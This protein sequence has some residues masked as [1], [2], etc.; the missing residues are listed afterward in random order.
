VTV[1]T[2]S[3]IQST[4]APCPEFSPW[5]QSVGMDL[6]F[7]DQKANVETAFQVKFVFTTQSI[8]SVGGNISIFL[9]A[10][11]FS[12]KFS[13]TATLSP[14]SGNAALGGCT[15]SDRSALSSTWLQIDCVVISAALAIG[16]QTIIFEA[17][18]LTTGPATEES[19]SGL[20]IMTSLD[21]LSTGVKTPALLGVRNVSMILDSS[22]Q[23]A[24]QITNQTVSFMFSTMAFLRANQLIIVTLP[25]RYFSGKSSPQA[26]ITP[27]SGISFVS[28]CT[29]TAS[30]LKI[31]C[32]S[33]I[34]STLAA[35]SFRLVFA[36]G[37]LTVGSV[38]KLIGFKGDLLCI[39]DL[40]FYVIM[41]I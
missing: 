29:L 20:K 2:T 3:N 27:P 9:S 37:E 25:E 17:G 40:L 5:I 16:Q 39:L 35:G 1:Q 32:K 18:E 19:A 7:S 21:G 22:D 31:E 11:Y 24:F 34:T 13:P 14:V 8:L 6:H 38:F 4:G 12:G 23:F 41:Y 30:L 36:A 33:H 28:P 15:L 10:S 26:T